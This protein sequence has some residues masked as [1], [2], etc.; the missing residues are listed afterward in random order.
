MA[1]IKVIGLARLQS[2]ESGCPWRFS[3][4]RRCF[5]LRRP[6]AFSSRGRTRAVT[7]QRPRGTPHDERVDSSICFST[8][9][10]VLL[11]PEQE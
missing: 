1:C 5:F 3:P 7:L 6:G 2:P 10:P 4:N 8:P 9:F 11:H